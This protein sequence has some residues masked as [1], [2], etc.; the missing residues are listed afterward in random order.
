MCKLRLLHTTYRHSAE[1]RL[2]T[3]VETKLQLAYRHSQHQIS[4]GWP[5]Q[6]VS[7]MAYPLCTRWASPKRISTSLDQQPLARPWTTLWNLSTF[8]LTSALLACRFGAVFNTSLSLS[9][10]TSTNIST[11]LIP[12]CP[13][14]FFSHPTVLDQ[15]SLPS[16]TASP[17]SFVFP[18]YLLSV[19][20]PSLAR[21]TKPH[22]QGTLFPTKMHSKIAMAA[23][24]VGAASA[25]PYMTASS[26]SSAAR[27]MTATAIGVSYTT[28]SAA[29]YQSGS[30][31]TSTSSAASYTSSDAG[32]IAIPPPIIVGP[33]ASAAAKASNA[34]LLLEV[35]E[36]AT[37]I[38]KF[39][40][41]LTVDGNGTTLLSGSDLSD[42]L[43]F[44]FNKAANMGAGGRILV[45]S[46]AN[47]PILND[48]GISGAVAFLNPCGMN[49]PHTHP[50]ATE[51]LTLVQGQLQTGFMLENTFAA[52]MDGSGALTTQ[53]SAELTPFQ[54][55]IFPKGSIHFQFNPTCEPATFVSALS[56]EDP[57]TSQIA[58]NFFF[59]NETIVDI[60]LNPDE[61]VSVDGNNIDM[62]RKK[63]P[64]NLVQ[65]VDQCLD[66]CKQH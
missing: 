24:L 57:G 11:N 23:A 45:A 48:E 55:T 20:T 59:L 54:S 13:P 31:S 18:Y 62:F 37:N 9:Y 32:S 3:S 63:L 46:E 6:H 42:R 52:P 29:P 39:N 44:D 64:A 21:P 5:R 66:A 36:Q 12:L 65:A 30:S 60:A 40:K 10:T 2:G 35:N 58:Q 34:A 43:V 51:F 50:R 53:V 19:T 22:S 49:T 1:R 15:P 26:S 16:N 33:A 25:A 27:Y 56:S 7:R 14:P 4:H 61:T 28:S 38:G 41:L 17:I 47:F 8:C